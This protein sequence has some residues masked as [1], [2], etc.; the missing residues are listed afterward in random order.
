METRST[1]SKESS[2]AIQSWSMRLPLDW[3]V[4][5]VML[6][7]ALLLCIRW[8]VA[9]NFDFK[10]YLEICFYLIIVAVAATLGLVLGRELVN[11]IGKKNESL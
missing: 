8:N 4:S 10:I 7:V 3:T 2:L 5:L 9:I 6:A 1:N 11:I